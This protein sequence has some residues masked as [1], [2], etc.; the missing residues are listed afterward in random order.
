M[1]RPVWLGF[2]LRL[3]RL[4]FVHNNVMALLLGVLLHTPVYSLVLNL[5]MS[6]TPHSSSSNW[7]DFFIYKSWELEQIILL[8]IKLDGTRLLIVALA[9]MDVSD[10]ELCVILEELDKVIADVSDL[11]LSNW[12]LNIICAVDSFEATS[13]ML[14]VTHITQCDTQ[15]VNATRDILVLFVAQCTLTKKHRNGLWLDWMNSFENWWMW[16]FEPLLY[17]LLNTSLF[18][19]LLATVAPH[20]NLVLVKGARSRYFR[21]FQHWSNGHRIN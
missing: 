14:R 13:L 12:L 10:Q 19:Y 4:C 11:P 9:I 17:I 7:I 16:E 6:Y 5:V 8:L 2:V 1:R 3:L 21:Q 20:Q 18:S 15:Y